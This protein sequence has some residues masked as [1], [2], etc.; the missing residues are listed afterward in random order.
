MKGFSIRNYW[1]HFN[2]NISGLHSWDSWQELDT[3]ATANPPKRRTQRLQFHNCTLQLILVVTN[4]Q[5][6]HKLFGRVAQMKRFLSATY[7]TQCHWIYNWNHVLCLAESKMKFFFL[8]FWGKQ[9]LKEEKKHNP[10]VNY[11][12]DSVIIFFSSWSRGSYEGA[13]SGC[14]CQVMIAI[15]T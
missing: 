4:F 9:E 8:M 7:K 3:W 11:F 1:I 12:Y 14:F 15:W 13:I 6:P 10:T 5:N 2:L